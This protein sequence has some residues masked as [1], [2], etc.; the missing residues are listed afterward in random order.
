[1][2]FDITHKIIK[3][4]RLFVIYDKKTDTIKI[5]QNIIVKD[6]QKIIFLD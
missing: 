5:N 6:I 4:K 3:I 2:I 1:M